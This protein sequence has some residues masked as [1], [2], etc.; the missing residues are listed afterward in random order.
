LATK[1]EELAIQLKLC[2]HIELVL[3]GLVIVLLVTLLFYTN[4][5]CTRSVDW[6]NQKE[7]DIEYWH[8]PRVVLAPVSAHART[9]P[10]QK[11]ILFSNFSDKVLA[12]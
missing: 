5:D 4:S 9:P 11:N 1:Q 10:P 6:N 2:L 12:I 3:V 7:N 8:T